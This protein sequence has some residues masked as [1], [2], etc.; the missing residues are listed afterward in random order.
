VTSTASATIGASG[1]L[2]KV[3][4]IWGEA[5]GTLE[6][7]LD[8]GNTKTLAKTI[9]SDVTMTI[10]K[11]TSVA[12]FRG[13]RYVGGTFDYSYCF[14]TTGMPA[15]YG[16]VKWD[17]GRFSSYGYPGSG[18]QRCDLAPQDPIAAAAKRTVCPKR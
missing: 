18:G 14:W 5:T 4:S 12:W 2:K 16:V 3:V 1:M 13:Y 15:G 8:V 17:Q 11:A 10:P 7:R 6:M 9:T